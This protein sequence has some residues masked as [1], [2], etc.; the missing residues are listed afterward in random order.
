MVERTKMIVDT[1]PL[2]SLEATARYLGV[3]RWT[4]YRMLDTGELRSVTIGGRRKVRP[5]D[6][7]AM[8]DAS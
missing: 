2:M 5:V 1:R 4:V 7:D 6:L 3:S 8:L